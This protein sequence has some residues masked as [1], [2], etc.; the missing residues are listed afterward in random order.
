[1]GDEADR[2]ERERQ[3][4]NRQLPALER[5]RVIEPCELLLVANVEDGKAAVASDEVVV[6]DGRM[7]RLV[8]SMYSFSSSFAFR[9]ETP[10]GASA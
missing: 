2:R 7:P 6:Q 1:L 8:P 5:A 4:M 9:A 3:W 10:F